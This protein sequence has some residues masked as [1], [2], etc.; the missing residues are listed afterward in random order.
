[1]L[2]TALPAD[3][4]AGLPPLQ[5]KFVEPSLNVTVPVAPDVTFAVKVTVLFE[6]EV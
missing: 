1:V 2:H 3:S 4:A 6:P 5:V